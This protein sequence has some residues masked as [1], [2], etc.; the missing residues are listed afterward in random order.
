M[1]I[2]LWVIPREFERTDSWHE[3]VIRV[4][5]A[6]AELRDNTKTD[7]SITPETSTDK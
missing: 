7:D 4:R 6:F 3:Q 5:C 1:L 2:S